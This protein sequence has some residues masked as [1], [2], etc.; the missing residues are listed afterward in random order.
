[1]CQ[2]ESIGKVRVNR[3]GKIRDNSG[4]SYLA[5]DEGG[6]GR[7]GTFFDRPCGLL[8]LVLL[9]IFTST[10]TPKGSSAT[11][12]PSSPTS[13]LSVLVPLVLL[14]LLRLLLLLL[15][16]WRGTRTLDSAYLFSGLRLL[17]E[18]TTIL[19]LSRTS[20]LPSKDGLAFDVVGL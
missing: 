19:G 6:S 3:T 5:K 20:L 7:R 1:V 17:L 2:R 15:E 11:S 12:S 16:G 8:L 9:F 14:L 13:S 10:C 4:G 18:G